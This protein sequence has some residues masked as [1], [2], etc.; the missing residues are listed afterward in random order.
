MPHFT[1]SD[2]GLRCLPRLVQDT[3]HHGVKVGLFFPNS[4]QYST[5]SG[6]EIESMMV[7]RL[8]YLR[9]MFTLFILATR[10]EFPRD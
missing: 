8:R 9:R 2:M 6:C 10:Q 7:L 5:R 1:A 4:K 3:R